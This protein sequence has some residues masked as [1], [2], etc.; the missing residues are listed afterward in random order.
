MRSAGNTA[1][2]PAATARSRSTARS[3]SISTTAR[4]R[5]ERR[6]VH[7]EATAEGSPSPG[8]VPI[9]SISGR[10]PP[11]AVSGSSLRL[12]SSTV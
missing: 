9:T 10:C 6:L 1:S 3:V 12:L 7:D 4:G 8:P 2:T 5:V 11:D